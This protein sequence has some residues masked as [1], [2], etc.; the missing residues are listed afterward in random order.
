MIK[1]FGHNKLL[2]FWEGI[3]PKSKDG[4]QAFLKLELSLMEA[5]LASTIPA[6]HING[7]KIKEGEGSYGPKK[8][9]L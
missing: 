2:A 6:V 9:S 8:Q 4:M 7:V 1:K 3:T 5:G